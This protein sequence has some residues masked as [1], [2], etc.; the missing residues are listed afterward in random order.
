MGVAY[1][2]LRCFPEAIA[3]LQQAQGPA[4]AWPH[5][6]AKVLHNLGAALNSVRSFSPA[7]SVHRQAA[8]LYGQTSPGT[9]VSLVAQPSHLSVTQCVRA[10]V[11][12]LW[13]AVE[14][15]RGASV[16]W[17]SPAVSWAMKT[18]QPRASSSLC[19]ASETQVSSV[20]SHHLSMCDHT[21]LYLCVHRRPPGPGAGVRGVGGVLPEAEEAAQS[22]A[23][24]STGSE[25]GRALPGNFTCHAHTTLP[26]P[27]AS[28]V[29]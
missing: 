9:P 2:C 22:G 19:R 11:Q 20:M 26:L 25:C 28:P 29:C 8:S 13:V 18:R 7:V 6:L 21:C 1:C 23:G 16:T 10:C 14:T 24:V 15:R 12:D 27:V 3:C 4:S 17:R 5:L